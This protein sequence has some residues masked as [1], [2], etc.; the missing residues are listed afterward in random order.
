MN[1]S[2]ALA[3]VLVDEL[4]R[5]GVREAVLCP[6]SRSAPLAYALQQADREGRLR[7]HVR[8]DERSAAF[9][10]LGLA[11]ATRTPAVVVTTSGTAVANLHPAVL[12]AHHGQVPLLLV[13]A[14][15]PPELRGTG[16]NQTTTQPGM[17]GAAVRWSQELGAPERRPGQGASWRSA[18][19]RALAATRG[20]P[21]G[22]AGP[23]HLNVPLR[24]PLVPTDEAGWPDSLGGRDGGK[25]WV[26][27]PAARPAQAS[28]PVT[29]VPRTLVV[30][31]DLPEP[32]QA[33]AA[34]AWARR[35]LW[36]VVAE[37]FGVGV[38]GAVPHGPLLLG[39]E[40]WLDA[41][42][43]ERVITVG[44][45]TLARPVAR[46]LRRPGLRVET[47][48]AGP[49]WTDPGHVVSAV[50]PLGVLDHPVEGGDADWAQE[51]QQAGA[52]LAKAVAEA[53][54]PWP[55]G[56]AVSQTLLASA[57]PGA[58]LF[59]GS[60]NAVRD[61]DLSGDRAGGAPTVLASRGLAGIDGCVSTAVG[62]ALA[63]PDPTYALL[64]DLTFLHDANGLLMGAAE[65]RPDLTLVVVNDDGG[66]IFTLLEPGEPERAG[67]FER[68][69]GTPTGTDLAALCAAH[70]VPHARAQ[71][72]E[73]LADEVRERPQGLRVVEVRVDRAT[74]RAAHGRLRQLAA[75]A[76]AGLG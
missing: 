21:T 58:S 15:R 43:P 70:G 2:T 17:F 13:S 72:R 56:L 42:Q 3:T 44:R 71:S 9:L 11:K 41:H 19:C 75:D 34:V 18:V 64:G 36:P 59:V 37:P 31:G 23:A 49:E 40:P 60:S 35:S 24:E 8:V 67:D 27:V 45:T 74:H 20:V 39:V 66:G 54:Q 52:V 57:S 48:S 33:A 29:G 6:G 62:L 28:T 32:G 30:V 16:A 46:L 47:V 76:L 69:F 4:V 38:D 14:D 73:D 68:V 53:G 10:A 65:P 51:W 26:D 63:S 1:P 5:D 22:V 61:L 7:L 25:P 12:E 55:S 50:H